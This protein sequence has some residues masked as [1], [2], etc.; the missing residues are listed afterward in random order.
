MKELE[1]EFMLSGFQYLQEKRNE[2]FAIYS[3][4][5]NNKQ[6]GYE[7]IIIGKQKAGKINRGGIEIEVEAKELY[8]T[9]KRWGDKGWTYK[10][11]KSAEK[12]FEELN[13]E[14]TAK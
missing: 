13:A 12:K 5:L 14:K 4:W 2:K 8:P 9:E 1:K 6:M 3:Q 11:I 10:D 7:V